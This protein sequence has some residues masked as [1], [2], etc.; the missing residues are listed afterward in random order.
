MRPKATRA[1]KRKSIALS[2]KPPPALARKRTRTP[3]AKAPCKGRASKRPA[4][5]GKEKR[6]AGKRER[7][8]CGIAVKPP[9]LPFIGTCRMMEKDADADDEDD[10]DDD[11]DDRSSGDRRKAD[12]LDERARMMCSNQRHRA[13]MCRQNERCDV[14]QEEPCS[15]CCVS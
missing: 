4:A 1:R 2:C 8:A 5:D 11:D 7:T 15:C 3:P 14:C 6:G 10:D 13:E 12:D 9:L